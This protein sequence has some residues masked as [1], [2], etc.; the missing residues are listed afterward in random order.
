[1]QGQRRDQS[2]AEPGTVAF[3]TRNSD[4]GAAGGKTLHSL[5]YGK[6][7]VNTNVKKGVMTRSRDNITVTINLIHLTFLPF[8]FVSN[9]LINL[10]FV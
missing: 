8:K 4:Q 6:N 9:D 2:D 10:K 5:K 1:M 3:P 7:N